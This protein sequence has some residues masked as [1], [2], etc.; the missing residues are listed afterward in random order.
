ML[1]LQL[2]PGVSSP[3][4][5][6]TNFILL[7]LT[8]SQ[9]REVD[10]WLIKNQPQV[11]YLLEENALKQLLYEVYEAGIQTQLTLERKNNE[12]EEEDDD[13]NEAEE[14]KIQEEV[15]SRIQ[16]DKL[17]C[18]SSILIQNL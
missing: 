10:K 17:T 2:R 14:A 9:Q 4:I 12:E 15:K 11:Q 3:G 6:T 8:T 5:F 7:M 13:A 16:D 1:C 18:Y